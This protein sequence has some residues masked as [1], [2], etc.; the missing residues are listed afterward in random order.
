MPKSL[1][2][3][4]DLEYHWPEA[5][6][7]LLTGKSNWPTD[8]DLGAWSRS[9]SAFI[10]SFT[11]AAETLVDAVTTGKQRADRI[12]WPLLYLYRHTVELALKDC[13]ID[14]ATFLGEPLDF[15][16]HHRLKDINDILLQLLA[17]L[18]FPT[19]DA[20][21]SAFSHILED[22]D[23]FDPSGTAFRYPTD[24]KGAPHVLPV[25]HVDIV[26]LQRGV[27]KLLNF[28]DCTSQQIEV[29]ARNL[30]LS[31]VA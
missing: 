18:D 10:W 21:V 30:S 17:K 29:W 20:S 6:D 25:T 23:Q 9:Y 31:G 27:M 24:R 3:L 2:E 8:A 13:L 4:V 26:D 7:Q 5:G 14:A 19:N 12:A 11:N 22:L 16:N 28:L 1:L 15:P